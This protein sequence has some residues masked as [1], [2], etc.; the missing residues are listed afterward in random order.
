MTLQYLMYRSRTQ[1]VYAYSVNNFLRLRQN[2]D[3][4]KKKMAHSNCVYA[5]AQWQKAIL[6]V[7]WSLKT[8]KEL[9]KGVDPEA[10]TFAY[11]NNNR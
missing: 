9:Q 2:K 8:G 3:G 5:H 11:T 6:T 10:S 7:S 1:T 4:L